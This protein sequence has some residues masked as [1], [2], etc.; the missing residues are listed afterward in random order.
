MKI[1]KRTDRTFENLLLEASDE[2]KQLNLPLQQNNPEEISKTI[3]PTPGFC[4][5]TKNNDGQK[6]FLNICHSSELPKPPEIDEDMLRSILNSDDPTTYRIPMS[7]GEV[8]RDQDKGGRICAVY[9]IIINSDYY[10]E[11]NNSQ[12][13]KQFLITVCLE[14]IEDKYNI[15]LDKESYV[16][17]KNKKYH[18]TMPQH[19][20]K[21]R[22][23]PL[24]TEIDESVPKTEKATDNS[25]VS[26]KD[27]SNK[28]V[29]SYTIMKEPVEGHPKT[30]FCEINLSGMRS[31]DLS[32][33]LGEDRIVL[34]TKNDIYNL[35]VFLP[36][37]IEQEKS[38]AHFIT[39]KQKM[40][41]KMPVVQEIKT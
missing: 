8:R 41:I 40:K 20:I 37:F 26:E 33:Y 22:P 6:V 1:T 35:D 16:I 27:S 12:V 11:V 34:S 39:P 15:S 9:D 23:K 31:E 5:K 38:I 14:G 25:L 2:L 3:H 18:G 10:K 19:N 29:P 28:K 13:F 4:L 32:L 24:V 7:L 21:I 30:L 17:L 36:Y